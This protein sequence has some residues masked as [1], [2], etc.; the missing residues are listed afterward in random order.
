MTTIFHDHHHHHQS[1]HYIMWQY[2]NF[3]NEIFSRYDKQL[4]LW[5]NA[6]GRNS[7]STTVQFEFTFM[8]VGGSFLKGVILGFFCRTIFIYINLK[9]LKLGS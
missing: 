6:K 1:W 4:I 3:D 2:R 7:I 8:S 9:V 5:Q